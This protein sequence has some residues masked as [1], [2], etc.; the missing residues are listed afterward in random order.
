MPL[1]SFV[2][3]VF[4]LIFL[5]ESSLYNWHT[6]VKNLKCKSGIRKSYIKQHVLWK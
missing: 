5:F 2:I 1:P 6:N 3:S 4:S